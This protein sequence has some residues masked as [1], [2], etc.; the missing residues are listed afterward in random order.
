[1]KKELLHKLSRNKGGKW[2]QRKQ[3]KEKHN[4]IQAIQSGVETQTEN[5]K[6]LLEKTNDWMALSLQS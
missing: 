1:M 5:V 6:M 3:I 2:K 4:A